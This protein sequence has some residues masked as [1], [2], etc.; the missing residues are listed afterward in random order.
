MVERPTLRQKN[1]FLP[2][3]WKETRRHF[4]ITTAL[5]HPFKILDS[6]SYHNLILQNR[7]LTSLILCYRGSTLHLCILTKH[8]MLHKWQNSILKKTIIPSVFWIVAKIPESTCLSNSFMLNIC[9]LK[10]ECVC[11]LR[12]CFPCNCKQRWQAHIDTTG[13][14]TQLY[15]TYLLHTCTTSVHITSFL[16]AQTR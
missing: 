10:S 12:H 14:F 9:T 7:L 3:K 5:L 8:L 13:F 1:F 6:S 15:W 16:I 4:C 2:L 11:E